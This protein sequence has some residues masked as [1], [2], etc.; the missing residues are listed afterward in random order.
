MELG[1]LLL[2]AKQGGQALKIKIG[3]EL[4]TRVSSAKLL[5]IQF[6]DDLQWRTQI[7]GK[8]GLLSAL[9]SRLHS[10]T[11]NEP[12]FSKIGGKSCRWTLHLED[13]IRTTTNGKSQDVKGRS[14]M[15]N[16]KGHSTTTEQNAQSVK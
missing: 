4:V 15:R 2:S 14:R 3:S 13:S 1:I 12:S 10:Q 16:L 6:Q 7:K 5:G 9:N 11:F 8:G